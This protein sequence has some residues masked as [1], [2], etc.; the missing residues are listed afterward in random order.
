MRLEIHCCDVTYYNDALE[1]Q[2]VAE[3]RCVAP[4]R[5]AAQQIQS[6]RFQPIHHDAQENDQTQKHFASVTAAAKWFATWHR[7]AKDPA[8]QR[9]GALV[10]KRDIRDTTSK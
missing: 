9:G 1:Y 7:T 5:F 2:T 4:H 6:A 8:A 3:Q 10:L